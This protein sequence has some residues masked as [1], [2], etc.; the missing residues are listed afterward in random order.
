[1]AL[2]RRSFLGT[3]SL[4]ALTSVAG[5]GREVHAQPEGQP[6]AL[7]SNFPAHDPALV[8]EFV[9]ASHGNVA[10]V[11]ELLQG[12]PALAKSA[13]DWGYGDWETALGAASHVGSREIAELLL[14]NGAPATI[15][16]AAML[17][18][19]D[20]VKAFVTASP[21]IHRTKGP[22][23]IPLLVHAQLGKAAEVIKYLESLGG[24]DEAD[25]NDPVNDADQAAILGTYTFGPGATERFT[26][27]RNNR[28]VLTIQREGAFERNLSHQ[29]E[30]V[31][32]PAGAEHVRIRFAPGAP[33]PELRVEDGPLVVIARRA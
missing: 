7:A 23:G 17:G 11:K 24:A 32:H 25:R 22:H 18:Q 5:S 9:G 8:R 31:F 26:I 27:A 29:G 21:G 13:W 12:R 30:R 15:F 10:R 14:A 6:T 28:G 4:L 16:S 2:S 1:M 33:S 19:L 3:T 20:A